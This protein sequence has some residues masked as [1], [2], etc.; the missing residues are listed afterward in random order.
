MT[1]VLRFDCGTS[2][3]KPWQS[4]NG[5]KMFV[6]AEVRHSYFFSLLKKGERVTTSILTGAYCW[7]SFSF[8]EKLGTL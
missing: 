8:A 2:M 3:G 4:G 1:A 6:K 7:M 5:T